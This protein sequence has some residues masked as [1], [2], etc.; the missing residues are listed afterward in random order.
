MISLETL[1]LMHVSASI[2]KGFQSI[3]KLDH[4]MRERHQMQNRESSHTNRE[5]KGLVQAWF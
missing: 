2:Y 5:R 4:G 3:A 1:T